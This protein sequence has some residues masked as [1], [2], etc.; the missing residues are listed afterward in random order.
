V[1][2]EIAKEYAGPIHDSAAEVLRMAQKPFCQR[3]GNKIS[4]KTT[5]LKTALLE[6]KDIDRFWSKVDKSSDCWLWTDVLAR[7]GYG[8]LGIGGRAGRKVQAHRLAYELMN[9]EIPAGLQIDH[10]CRV[11]HCVNPA[12]LQAVTQRTNLLRGNGA[13]ARHARQTHCIRGH[14][15]SGM[16]SLGRRICAICRREAKRR[17]RNGIA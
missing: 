8:Y 5:D 7:N 10:L 2:H 4:M 6:Q 12:H 16:D 3:D 1:L 9:G 13:S 11:R 17:R 14:P 15:F